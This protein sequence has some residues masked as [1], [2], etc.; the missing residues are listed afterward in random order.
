MSAQND[1]FQYLVQQYLN[2]KCTAEELAEFWEQ[3]RQLK[4]ETVFQ[5]ELEAHWQRS[6]AGNEAPALGWESVLQQ[7]FTKAE[8]YMQEPAAMPVWRRPVFRWAAAAMVVLSLGVAAYFL[9]NNKKTTGTAG[10]VATTTVQDVPAPQNNRATITLANG[11]TIYLDSAGNGA[12]ASEG[13]VQVVKL[14]DGQIAYKGA[15]SELVYNTLTNPRG[16]RVIDMMLSDGSRIWLNAGSSITYPVSFVGD[17]RKVEIKG[18]VYFEVAPLNP[19]GGQKKVPFIVDVADPS[20]S[21]RASKVEVLGTHFNIN[22]YDDE[23]DVRVTL[24]EGSVRVVSR[25][26]AIGKRESA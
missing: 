14:A 16:S 25:E 1:R 4:D 20:G 11:Q 9:L 19:K 24:L 7:V 23:P 18:E 17:E 3:V 21:G 5:P 8:P 2:D 15:A 26:T 13:N 10:P 22:A 6:A 12:L